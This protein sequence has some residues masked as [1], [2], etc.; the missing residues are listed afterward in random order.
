MS[1]LYHKSFT[2]AILLFEALNGPFF[3]GIHLEKWLIRK[4]RRVRRAAGQR[5]VFGS[6]E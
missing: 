1:L 5:R 3:E 4:N 6:S 2:A